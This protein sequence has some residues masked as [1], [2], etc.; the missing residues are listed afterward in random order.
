MAQCTPAIRMN[1]LRAFQSWK[2]EATHIIYFGDPSPDLI[3][4]TCICSEQFPKIIR[5]VDFCAAMPG[6]SAII[7]ADIQLGSGVGKV[8][9]RVAAQGGTSAVSW[10]WETGDGAPKVVD[11]GMDF[12]AAKQEVWNKVSTIYPDEYRIGH[13]SWDAIMLGALNIADQRGIFDLTRHRL[14]FHPKHEDRHR[15]FFIADNTRTE[16]RDNVC[17]PSRCLRD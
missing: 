4:A 5:L 14:V 16:C 12:F 1:Q 9:D 15:P 3:G 13:S 17:W 7:N 11:N 6:W 2:K 10:R 8:L